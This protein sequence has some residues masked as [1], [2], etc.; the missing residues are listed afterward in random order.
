[1]DKYDPYDS[2]FQICSS[3]RIETAIWRCFRYIREDIPADAL[4]LLLFDPGLGFMEAVAEATHEGGKAQ[5]IKTQFPAPIREQLRAFIKD[6]GGNPACQI[7]D[8]LRDD[9]M[10]RLVARDLNTPD[11]SG[12]LLDLILE[13]EYL[14]VVAAT[15]TKGEKFTEEHARLM[16]SVHNPLAMASAKFQRQRTLKELSDRLAENY[17]LLQEDL[18]SITGDKVIGAGFGLKGVMEMV[19]QVAPADT[20]VL[21]L[22]ETGVGKEIIANTIHRLSSRKNNPLIKVDCAAISE[23]L[24]E[25]ELFGHEKGSFTGAFSRVRGRFERADGGTLFLDEIG[26]LSPETQK[27]I[28]RVLEEGVIERVGGSETISVDVRIIAAT[29]RPLETMVADAQFRKDLFYR[30]NIFPILIPPLRDRKEDIPRFVDHFMKI[31]SRKIKL[32]SIATLASGAIDRLMAYKWPGNIRELKNCVERE[33]LINGGKPL[34]FSSLHATMPENRELSVEH[35][36]DGSFNLDR[37]IARHIRKIMDMTGGRV[38]GI[39]GAA[40]LLGVHPRTLQYRM[41]KL[42]IPFGRNYKR[43]QSVSQKTAL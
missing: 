22:G 30:L 2:R 5:S 20:P 13:D 29:H 11:E 3:P 43:V 17:R 6:L 27:K 24:V 15:N 16:L 35:L 28:L 42:N 33:L 21:L 25:N 39:H 32:S 23:S 40:R 36:A 7:I 34:T 26:E 38:E 10:A 9:D 19:Y 18:I 12:L 14:G 31:K 4:T 8:R 1:M 37:T 41:K